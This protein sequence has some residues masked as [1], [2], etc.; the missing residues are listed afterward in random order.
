[1]HIGYIHLDY[2][3]WQSG[4]YNVQEIGLGKAMVQ[5]GHSFTIVYWVSKNDERCGKTVKIQDGIYKVYLSYKWRCVHHIIP[6]MKKLMHLHL[7]VL[8]LQCDNLVGVPFAVSY[9]LDHQ[10]PH[11]CYVG[12]LHSSSKKSVSRMIVDIIT[13]R[14]YFYLRKTKV[15]AKTLAVVEELHRHGVKSASFAPV[16]LDTDVIPTENRSKL[17]IKSDLK[18]PVD[19][20]IIVCICALRHD[21]HPLD[22]LDLAELLSDNFYIVHIGSAWTAEKE[23]KER[24]AK[25]GNLEKVHYIG[26]IPN[27]KV[28]AYY[29]IADYVVNFNPNE[30]FGM[31]ILEAM[32]HGCTV[33]ARHAP[34]P[35]CIIEN[36]KSGFLCNSVVEMADIIKNNSH[37]E[38]AEKCIENNFLWISTAKSFLL[39]IIPND[40]NKK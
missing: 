26:T 30:I 24:L 16:G 6:D 13:Y 14:N 23:Y 15:F 4:S 3:E 37:A 40:E 11:Y 1:M 33:V 17:Q 18:I 29:E 35:D 34:G 19:K 8:H 20:K 36:G 9:C 12:T 5:L 39:D 21:K 7:D 32:Y 31:A 28:H 38:C 2:G 22:L 10:I 25:G 27:K